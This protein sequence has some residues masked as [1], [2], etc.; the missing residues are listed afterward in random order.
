MPQ[1]KIL[2][3][4]LP[5]HGQNIETTQLQEKHPKQ[6]ETLSSRDTEIDLLIQKELKEM[7][8]DELMRVYSVDDDGFIRD[9]LVNPEY[10][11]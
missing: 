6:L 11:E 5:R 2:K 10:E 8:G 1:K 7:R 4:S 9:K 3:T